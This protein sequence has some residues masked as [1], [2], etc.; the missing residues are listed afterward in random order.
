[1]GQKS[2]LTFGC[3]LELFSFNKEKE[4]KREKQLIQTN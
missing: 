3:K 1:M 2:F 4:G